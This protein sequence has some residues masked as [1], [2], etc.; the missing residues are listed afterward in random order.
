[1]TLSTPDLSWLDRTHYPFASNFFEIDG[2]RMH[3]VDHGQGAPIVMVHGT[4][5]WSFVYREMIK[6]LAPHYRC[7]APDQL[8]FG[9]SDKPAHASY[10]PVEHA[11]RLRALIEHLG[12]RDITLIV[13]D[14]G[15]PIG[16]SYAVE[17]PHNLRALVILNT[18]M[19]S[20]R[21]EPVA[22]LAGLTSRGRLG[23]V[24]FQR[25]NFELRVLFNLAWGKRSLLSPALYQHYLKPFSQPHDRL[26]LQ[27]M[28]GEL[29][30]SSP[31]YDQLWQRRE[32]IA[33]I[34]ALLLWGQK[35]PIFKTRHLARW[36]ALFAHAQTVTFPQ[37]GHF[38]QEEARETLGPLVE[39]FLATQRAE[40]TLGTP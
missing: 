28:A 2:A 39:Q 15:G 22:E 40:Q 31:W 1:M 30:D 27:A 38:V 35:D 25:L 18:W 32:Q 9:L 33:A 17:Q 21:G 3:Y 37:A 10:R 24:L 7:I 20:L 5:T 8:G 4:G 14:F 13:H 12:L 11:R 36:Q 34:P 26:V 19:W 29:R 16:L 23:A 6:V